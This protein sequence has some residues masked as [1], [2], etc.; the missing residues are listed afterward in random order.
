M[1]RPA[2]L[3]VSNISSSTRARDLAYEFERFGRLIR[4][5]IPSGRSYAFVEFEDDRD[6]ED[7][8]DDM[9]GRRFE[10]RRL[11]VEVCCEKKFGSLLYQGIDADIYLFTRLLFAI[12]IPL[13]HHLSIFF[14]PLYAHVCHFVAICTLC[15]SLFLFSSFVQFLRLI[16]VHFSCLI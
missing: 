7:A 14:A 16:Y 12:E 4:C 6:A 13:L 5:D 10:G 1:P 3:Y 9:N 8:L 15:V 11:V 2:T